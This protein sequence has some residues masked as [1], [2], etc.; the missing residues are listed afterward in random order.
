MKY[1]LIIAILGFSDLALAD[2]N[3]LPLTQCANGKVLRSFELENGRAK[4]VTVVESVPKGGFEDAAMTAIKHED[5]SGM[6]LAK[7]KIFTKS[8]SFKARRGCITHSS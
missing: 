7:V 4:N 3:K 8:Y 1:L 5:F 6:K 2:K